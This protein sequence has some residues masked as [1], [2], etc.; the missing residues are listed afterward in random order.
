MIARKQHRRKPVGFQMTPM[1]DIVFLLIIFFLVSN[2]LAQREQRLPVDLPSAATGQRVSPDAKAPLSVTVQSDGQIWQA[3]EWLSLDRLLTRLKDRKKQQG[4]AVE[5]RVRC[6]RA[7]EYR[8]I[9]R[10]LR[11]AAEAG[12]WD[13]TFAVVESR[14]VSP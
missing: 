11:E 14:E 5:L 6:D 7:T 13:V 8:H 12:I 10:L 3:G 9:E 4:E 2:H 1:I